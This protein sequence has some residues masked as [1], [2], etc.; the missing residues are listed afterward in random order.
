MQ[1]QA[2]MTEVMTEMVSIIR[3]N[4][5]L[6]KKVREKQFDLEKNLRS[7]ETKL[8]ILL[9]LIGSIGGTIGLIKIIQ[10]VIRGG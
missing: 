5:E 7:I 3:S 6:I 8:F 10:S 4:N 1:I 9:S 2:N